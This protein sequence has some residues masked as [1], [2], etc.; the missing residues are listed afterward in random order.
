MECQSRV[1]HRYKNTAIDVDTGHMAGGPM[2][3]FQYEEVTPVDWRN[4]ARNFIEL[5]K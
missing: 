5:W 3:R 4:P 1:F 2:W